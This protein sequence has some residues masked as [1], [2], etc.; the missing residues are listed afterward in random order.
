MHIDARGFSLTETRDT[1]KNQEN[2]R[3]DQGNY[4]GERKSDL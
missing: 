2:K 4:S 1:V 3:S